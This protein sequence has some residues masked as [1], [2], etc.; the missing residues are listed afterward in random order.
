MRWRAL[1]EGK[2][3]MKQ[4][5]NSKQLT[6]EEV[7]EMAE[8]DTHMANKILQ[9][10]EDLC[11]TRQFWN[12]RRFE[13]RGMIKQSEH[14]EMA[15]ASQTHTHGKNLCT[16]GKTWLI[17][18]CISKSVSSYFYYF[19]WQ[20]R[21]STHVHGI[22]KWKDAPIIKWDKNKDNEEEMNGV[23]WYL[24]SLVTTMNPGLG[25]PVPECHLCQ[26]CTDEI[27][28]DMQDY[29]EL[30]NNDVVPHTIFVSEQYCR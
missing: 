20:H 28:Y 3:Y 18:P 17:I 19:E 29:I 13:L 2:V 7:Q 4:S 9:F 22:G 10:D 8:R 25:A 5:L 1:Q 6:I 16:N 30:V 26:K 27:C 14:Q 21:D 12:R 11:G 24:D 15:G 23:I